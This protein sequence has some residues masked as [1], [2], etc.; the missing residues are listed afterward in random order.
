MSIPG[1][2]GGGGGAQDVTQTQYTREAPDIEARRVQLMDT[3]ANLASKMLL[4]P[5]LSTSDPV[6]YTSP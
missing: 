6:E 2:G 5:F 3:A 1:M 4:K